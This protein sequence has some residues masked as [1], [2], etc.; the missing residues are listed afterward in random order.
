[1]LLGVMSPEWCAAMEGAWAQHFDTGGRAGGE[2]ADPWDEAI[3]DRLAV[4]NP[5]SLQITEALMPEPWLQLPYWTNVVTPHQVYKGQ[6]GSPLGKDPETDSSPTQSV[7]RDQA[8][9]FPEAGVLL[10]QTR[11]HHATHILLCNFT[12][13]NGSTE[14][15]P[16]THRMFDTDHNDMGGGYL[17]AQGR[18]LWSGAEGRASSVPSVNCN[19]PAG[20]IMV[21]DASR[22]A[23]SLL[24]SLCCLLTLVSHSMRATSTP[25]HSTC[26]LHRTQLTGPCY[27]YTDAHVASGSSQHHRHPAPD[28]EPDLLA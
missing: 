27:A 19:A 1:V 13:E 14:L 22:P 2:K 26:I 4:E 6:W 3:M 20:S 16:G 18:E 25:L 5:W 11:D 10:P 23:P 9:F 7:H 8:H 21:R 15:W 17:N 28:A 12:D 24:S